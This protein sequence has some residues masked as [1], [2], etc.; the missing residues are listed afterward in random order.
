MKS[1]VSFPE[2]LIIRKLLLGAFLLLTCCGAQANIQAPSIAS[3]HEE[4]V[5]FPSGVCQQKGSGGPEDSRIFDEDQHASFEKQGFLV[6]SNLLDEELDP[7]VR[8]SDA[9]VGASKKSKAYFSSIEMGM[10]FQA[11]DLHNETS[12]KA[13]RRVAL[14]S[15]LPQ[16]AS[17]L[18]GLTGES[19]VRVLR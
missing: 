3:P 10:I 14:D 5:S 19:R 1:N 18:M 17:E 11:G 15:V 13:F 8:A 2:N 4:N 16:A 6:V 9:F 12:T 7:L